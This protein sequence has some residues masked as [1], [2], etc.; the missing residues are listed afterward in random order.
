MK[1]YIHQWTGTPAPVASSRSDSRLVLAFGGKRILAS[2]WGALAESFPGASLL[3]CSTAGEIFGTAVNDDTLVVARVDLDRTHIRAAS[4]TIERSSSRAAGHELALQ[5]EGP[6][7]R[8]VLVLS[9]GLRVNGSEL[10]TGMADRLG[11]D[12]VITG[13]LAA[14]GAAFE[15]TLV[16]VGDRLA[17]GQVGAIGFYGDALRVSA[18]SLGGWDPFGPERLVT[19]ADGNVVYE[20]DGKPALEL[21]KRYLGDHASGLPASAL[22]FP[23]SVRGDSGEGSVVRTILGVNEA[24]QSITFAGD[25]VQGAVARLMKANFERLVDGAVGAANAALEPLA[26]SPD[27]AIL[28]SCVGR[29]LVLQQRIEDE[30]EGVRTVMGATTPMIGFYSY[31]EISPAVTEARCELHNQTMTITTLSEAA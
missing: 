4:T 8:Y 9:D 12:V 13:G 21:Y 14:D 31:G 6:G 22:L 27:L 15:E 26:G 11:K 16:G 5:L 19:R 20:L 7:L 24:E 18:G 25:I 2:E 10:V 29:K 1:A 3:G 28:I 17:A 30:V 23:L